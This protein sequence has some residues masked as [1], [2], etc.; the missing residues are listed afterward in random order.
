MMAGTLRAGLHFHAEDMGQDLKSLGDWYEAD[1][2]RHG[3]AELILSYYGAGDP[4]YYGM[5]K[6]QALA[7][8]GPLRT[9]RHVN[10]RAPKRELL[11]ISAA[12]LRDRFAWL[13][14]G[15]RST[16][17][18][19][20]TI[21]VY[22]VTNRPDIHARLMRIYEAMG[23]PAEAARERALSGRGPDRRGF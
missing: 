16:A 13:R 4:R 5:L 8:V 6:T 15:E 19:G 23:C 1:Q 9:S 21:F 18:I 12:N 11:A 3:P 17:N 2:A 10:S 14:D 22:D 20:R 7:P